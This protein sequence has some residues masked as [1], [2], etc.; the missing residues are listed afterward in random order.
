[1]PRFPTQFNELLMFTA[2]TVAHAAK[3]EMPAG[4]P[5]NVRRGWDTGRVRKSGSPEKRDSEEDENGKVVEKSSALRW[6]G[7]AASSR[8]VAWASRGSVP[9][10][11]PGHHRPPGRGLRRRTTRRE[12]AAATEKAGRW[13]WRGVGTAPGAG[14][15]RRDPVPA[16]RVASRT[17]GKND[18]QKKTLVTRATKLSRKFPPTRRA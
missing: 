16:C 5:G 12:A 2:E 4:A 3:L 8:R 15:P 9:S 1:M 11:P 17:P 14:L 7:A 6:P 13:T 18:K 10:V